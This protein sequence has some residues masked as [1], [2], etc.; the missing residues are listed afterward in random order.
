MVKYYSRG[1][2]LSIFDVGR[3]GLVPALILC[4]FVE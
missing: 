2:L 1:G 4:D 3:A